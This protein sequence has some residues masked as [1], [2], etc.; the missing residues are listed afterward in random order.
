MGGIILSNARIITPFDEIYSGTVE[1]ENGVIRKVYYGKRSGGENLE[2]KILVPGFIDIHTHGIRGY[3][4]T[5]SALEGSVDRVVDALMAMSRAYSVHGVTRFLPT[6][7]TAPHEVLLIAA[8]GVAETIDSQRD[9]IEGALIEGLHMEGPYISREKAGAQNPRYIRSPSINELKEYWEASRGKLKTITLA[10]EVKGALEL[11]QYARSLGIHVSIGHTNATYEEAKAAIYAGANRATHLY[12]GMRQVHHREPGVVVALLESPQVYLEFICDYIHV[13]P[14]M[15]KY[16]IRCAGIE[17]IVAV[18]DSIIATDLPDGTYSLGGLEI[19]VK[20]GVSRLR[21]GALAGSTL[22]MDKALK[23][24]VKL[25]IPLK[26]AVRTLT[27]NPAIAVGIYNAGAIMPGYTA[28]LVV[29]DENLKV[30]SV[31]VRGENI[32]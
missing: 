17:R 19:I 7:V 12:N 30:E 23:N 24:L 27:Y 28:D 1:V 18:T 5:L 11:I 9:G 31:Y 21:N 22:T 3:D 8:K 16:T 29:L 20:D 25:G 10:P 6:T 26:D 4:V 15:I 13:S 2:G 32:L 14:I